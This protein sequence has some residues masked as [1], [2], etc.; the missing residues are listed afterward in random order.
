MARR[1]EDPTAEDE[2][3][4]PAFIIGVLKK[5]GVR[6]VIVGSFGAISQGIDLP[7][8]DI[9]IV[10]ALDSE[11]LAR[12]AEALDELEVQDKRDLTE[13]IRAELLEDPSLISETTFWNF[14]SPY[15]GVDLVLKPAGF[16]GGFEDLIE[17]ALIIEIAGPDN[18]SQTV[19][20]IVA[21]V[22]D[23]YESKSAARR[24]KDVRALPKFTHLHRP[25]ETREELRLRYQQERRAQSSPPSVTDKRRPDQ[26]GPPPG[27]L[28][29]KQGVDRLGRPYTRWVRPPG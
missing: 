17:K 8:T 25:A 22:K 19:E 3:L 14:S 12:L 24:A 11:N 15:G 16:P 1:G 21:D 28:V 13:D 23:I 26:P 18:S 29:K 2:D 20:A 7:M 10:P 27:R 5:L 4:Q 6:Y 9:D